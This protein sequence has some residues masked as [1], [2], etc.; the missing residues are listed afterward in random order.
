MS[1]LSDIAVI[2]ICTLAVLFAFFII[3]IFRFL[4]D[5]RGWENGKRDRP[6]NH[7]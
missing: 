2:G 1:V 5:L 7:R 4:V 3:P 6:E